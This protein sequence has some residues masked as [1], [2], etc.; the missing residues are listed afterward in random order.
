MKY[1]LRAITWFLP[2]REFKNREGLLHLRRYGIFVHPK[3]SIYFHCFLNSDS[4]QYHDH[5]FA[6]S[7]TIVLYGAYYD[8]VV[9]ADS[10]EPRFYHKERAQFSLDSFDGN[11]WHRVVLPAGSNE[12]WTVFWHGPRTKGWGYLDNEGKN[13]KAVS[14]SKWDQRTLDDGWQ[15]ATSGVGNFLRSLW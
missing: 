6:R 3:F 5:P 15:K 11:Y 8:L 9:E 10:T 2:C 7:W 1:L 12:V 4:E 13:Y 14:L